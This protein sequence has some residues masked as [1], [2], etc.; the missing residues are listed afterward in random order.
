MR[1]TLHQRTDSQALMQA[2][3]APY[4]TPDMT[5]YDVGCGEK[6]FAAFLKGR[7]AAHIGVDVDYGFYDTR[8]I[9]LVGSADDLPIADGSVQAILSSQVIEHLPD[10]DRAIAEAA[11]VLKPGGLLFLSYPYLYPIHAPPWDFARLSQFAMDRMLAAHGLELVERR[12]L[13]GFWYLL[14]AVTPI[15]LKDLPPLRPLGMGKGLGWVARVLCRGMH[16]LEA[17]GL[18]LMKRDLAAARMA[19][20]VTYVLVARRAGAETP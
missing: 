14:G 13:A 19:W 11:R 15:Y 17:A 1:E 5:L 6:P 10:P 2:M 9:D 20:A 3:M 16:G 8:H 18:R 12:T 4:L 7:V